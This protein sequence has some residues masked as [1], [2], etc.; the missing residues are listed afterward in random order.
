MLVSGIF[1]DLEKAFDCVSH[2]ILLNKLRYYGIR[3]KQYNLYE[4]YLLDRK[5]RT[6]ISNRIDSMKVNSRWTK[7]TNGVPQGST[8]GPLLFIIYISDLPKILEKMSTPILYAD[9]ACVLTS[10]A[11]IIEF[12]TTINEVY[13]ILD[14]WF[15]LNL[16][17]LN[18]IKTYYINFTAKTRSARD[19]GDLGAIITCANFTKFL[20]LTIQNDITWD[21]HIQDMIK[22]LNT[23]CYIIRNVKKK[24]SL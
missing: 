19:M 21:G 2:E 13:R 3:G 8:L 17:S 1:C 12:K 15:K 6:A 23:A 5:Q 18:I 16:M 11:N 22:K 7:T 4:S 14:D 9:A 20:G 10:H 24:W